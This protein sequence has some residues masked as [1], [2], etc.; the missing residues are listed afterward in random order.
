[1][2]KN[3]LHSPTAIEKRPAAQDDDAIQLAGRGAIRAP[4]P[5]SRRTKQIVPAALIAFLALLAGIATPLSA[6]D[7]QVKGLGWIGDRKAEQR[8]KLLIPHETANTL[9]ASTIEDAALVLSSGLTDEGYLR[10][11]I[12]AELTLE[13]DRHV[14]YP[15]DAQLEQPLPRPLAAIAA[16]LR[17]ER[18]QRFTLREITFTGLFALEPKNA[19]AFFVGEDR[20][21]PLDA[22]R[23]YSPGRLQRSAGNL[24]ETLRQMGYTHAEVKVGAVHID[25]ATGHVR[26]TIVVTEGRRS[27][28]D[29][30]R[31][32]LTDHSPEPATVK[33]GRI[34]APW[35][36]LW[37]QET[38]TAIRRWYFAH[39]FPDVRIALV[40][41]VVPQ[42]DGLDHVAVT[43]R[44]TPGEVVH[45]GAVR[46]IGNQNTRESTLRRLVKSSP[47]DLLN[48]IKFDNAEARLSQLGVFRTVD[49]H[50]NPPTA[51]VRDVVYNVTEGRRQE[52]SL[53]AGYGSY[54][55][56]RGGV[57]WQDYNLFGLA[58]STDLKLV[59]SMKS[60]EGEY[61]YTVP[62]LF[63]TTR[64]GT[65]RVFGLRQEELSFL[66]E[67]YGAN[68]AVL[69]PLRRVGV[70][71]TTGYTFKHVRDTN[72]ELA[73]QAT[74]QTGTDVGSIG[75]G[76]VR[77]RRDN[78][79]R[80][81]H[82]Y[83]LALQADLADRGLGGD[84]VYQQFVL[85]G[86]YHTPWGNGRWLHFGLS[87]GVVTT[88]GAPTD[89]PLPVSVLFFPG[90]D[91]SIRGYRRGGAAPRAANGQFIGAKSYVQANVEL[92]QA[93]TANW[94]AV[95]FG[96]AVGT[97][98]HLSDYPFNKE[99]Y[100]VGLGVRYQ[101]IIGPVRVEYGHN[102]NPRVGDPNGTLQLSIGFPF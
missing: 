98:V 57:E 25:A 11:T 58:H 93:L 28:V 99:L 1:M 56:L 27:V 19:R 47:G 10:P 51:A 7:L 55:Q 62:Q 100:S 78:P 94:S 34:G 75:I 48:P 17:I 97:A 96:D 88:S 35:N 16:T 39:G 59:Q 20:I 90:G 3:S 68:V 71:L 8:L 64:D 52:V 54:E 30:L 41:E 40:P 45:V 87:H 50:Y 43:V 38:T 101:T 46:F 82:G 44:V 13:G 26:A 77:E 14:S 29:S 102:L 36:S 67:E 60:S 92:E 49:L 24:T 23:L 95:V 72:N 66:H 2:I 61:T 84:V 80:P 69:W 91:G 63:G 21:I 6:A 9:N 15:L 12:K 32:I 74:D 33:A 89:N 4:R 5:D 18:G 42:A 73:T 65:A 79:L 76:L 53:L 22:E 31:F 85:A 86:S 83:K 81:H 70:T 37:R